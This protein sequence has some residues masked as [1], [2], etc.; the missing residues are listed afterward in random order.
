MMVMKYDFFFFSTYTII[1]ITD[2]AIYNMK[3]KF[4]CE[5]PTEALAQ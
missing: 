5:K 1:T 4:K 3:K 2:T